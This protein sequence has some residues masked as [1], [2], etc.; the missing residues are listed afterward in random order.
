M[1]DQDCRVED[2]VIDP[3]LSAAILFAVAVLICGCS[4]PEEKK[5]ETPPVEKQIVQEKAPAVKQ[6]MAEKV[7]PAAESTTMEEQAI[8]AAKEMGQQALEKEIEKLPEEQQQAVE[9]VKQYGEEG[10]KEQAEQ[11]VKEKAIEEAMKLPG[12]Y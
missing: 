8:K 7:E 9:M 11:A 5:A 3:L 6:E 4:K 2:T 1:A 12:K 10:N